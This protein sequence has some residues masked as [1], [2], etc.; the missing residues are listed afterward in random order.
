LGT[1]EGG[2]S[3]RDEVA[4]N[5]KKKGGRRTSRSPSLSFVTSCGRRK[6]LWG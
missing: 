4:Y 5:T 3:T 6:C 1:V 2:D